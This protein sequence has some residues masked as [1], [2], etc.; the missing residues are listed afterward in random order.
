[1]SIF[2]QLLPHFCRRRLV[3]VVVVVGVSASAP[4]RRS[5]RRLLSIIATFLPST[6]RRRCRCW[7]LVVVV[8]FSASAPHRRSRRRQFFVVVG[9]GFPCCGC[10]C[11]LLHLVSFSSAAASRRSLVILVYIRLTMHAT[12]MDPQHQV[13]NGPSAL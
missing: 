5:R 7:S 9:S 10:V 4:H 3:V 1:M 13:N 6:S 11:R 2:Y 8:G 12:T